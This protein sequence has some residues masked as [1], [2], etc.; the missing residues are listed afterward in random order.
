MQEFRTTR[1]AKQF[2]IARIIEEAE[3]E[4]NP[5]SARERKLLNFPSEPLPS[6][7]L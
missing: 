6:R 2:I 7:Q 1:E 4:G 3:R 5:L